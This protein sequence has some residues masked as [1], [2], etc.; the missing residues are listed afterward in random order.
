MRK[1]KNEIFSE[2]S[3]KLS[4]TMVSFFD[5][6]SRD[7]FFYF[8]V[9]VMEGIVS[10]LI[11]IV[12]TIITFFV[13]IFGLLVRWL[14][15]R[16]DMQQAQIDMLRKE[17]DVKGVKLSLQIQKVAK[18]ED[19]YENCEQEHQ[20]SKDQIA[21]MQQQIANF[22]KHAFSIVEAAAIR[23]KDDIFTEAEIAAKKII[24]E[25]ARVKRENHGD[26]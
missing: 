14:I 7:I 25:A 20:R 21:E 12:A 18:L 2:I 22:P 26:I 10:A 9:I 6:L 17:A 3:G 8:G 23:V 15:K 24:D 1:I 11:A 19:Q 4:P 16:D 13:G 5:Y